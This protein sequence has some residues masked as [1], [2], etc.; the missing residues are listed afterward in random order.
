MDARTPFPAGIRL[1]L[2]G[3]AASPLLAEA[4]AGD[5]LTIRPQA[6][7]LAVLHSDSLCAAVFDRQN[8]LIHATP[9]WAE[10]GFEPDFDHLCHAPAGQPITA[11]SDAPLPPLLL[12]A[13]PA[14]ASSWALPDAVLA[15]LGRPDA[16]MLVLTVQPQAAQTALDAAARTLGLTG[17]QGRVLIAILKAG[18]IRSAAQAL[19]IGYDTARSA[20]SDAMARVG[21]PRLPALLDRLTMLGLGIWPQGD[22]DQATLLADMLGLSE[23]QARLAVALALGQTRAEAAAATGISEAVAKKEIDQIFILTGVGSAAALVRRLAESRALA[24]L[25]RVAG[26][27]VWADEG[28]LP[29]HFVARPDGSRIAVSDYG[30]AGAPPVLVVHSSMTTRHVAAP[31][32]RALQAAGY[33]V[34][35]IDR[36]GFGRSDMVD[37]LCL[38][39]AAVDDFERVL[40]ALKLPSVAIVTRGAAQFVLA[41]GR[42]L[43][44]RLGRVVLVNPDPPSAHSGDVS[45]VVSVIK[46]LFLR[47]PTLVKGFARLLASQY[48][49]DKAPIII[50]RSVEASPPDRA[51]MADPAN[52]ADYYR[53]SRASITG[54]FSGYVA[55]QVAFATRD[56]DAPLKGKH[57]WTVLLGEHDMI[58]D[59]T[60]TA[61]YWRGV[62]P[63]STHITVAG[64]GRFLALTHEAALLTALAGA[65]TAP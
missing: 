44:Q 16:A 32:L 21:V 33:R 2:D 38:F 36:P 56:A 58:H 42:R 22:A 20:M 45:G 30:P 29:L 37:A 48:T 65:P 24:M 47:N 1:A 11:P 8:R 6:G 14:S 27:V 26:G 54:R 59:P 51:F 41:A 4:L 55:E 64:A 7:H 10:A 57:D 34:L 12:H 63:D 46:T 53:A 28:V 50:R 39:E 49:P 15:A 23:R 52:V 19:G 9:A 3:E 5:T 25:S 60:L 61:A 18:S 17:H 62:L 40:D 13:T 43:P 35:S 31:L